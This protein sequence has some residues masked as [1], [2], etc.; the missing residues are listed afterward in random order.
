MD[1]EHCERV[2]ILL[3]IY[4]YIYIYLIYLFEKKARPWAQSK[5]T[6]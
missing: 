4:I 1:R 5:E 3:N 2:W 6:W